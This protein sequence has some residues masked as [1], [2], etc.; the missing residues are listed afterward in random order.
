MGEGGLAL[1]NAGTPWLGTPWM[2]MPVGT[3]Y[4]LYAAAGDLD[5]NVYAAG[6]NGVVARYDGM[7]WDVL[8]TNSH[9]RLNGLHISPCGD[10][11]AAGIWGVI[12]RYGN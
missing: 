1:R 3:D 12:L 8:T 9:D 4:S 6:Y 2:P 5:G 7:S 10:I 11:Y